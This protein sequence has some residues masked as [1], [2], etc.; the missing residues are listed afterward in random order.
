[1]HVTNCIFINNTGSS[2]EAPILTAHGATTYLKDNTFLNNRI[3]DGTRGSIGNRNGKATIISE[4]GNLYDGNGYWNYDD[5][6]YYSFNGFN[7]NGDTKQDGSVIGCSLSS[8]L[9]SMGFSQVPNHPYSGPAY[10]TNVTAGTAFTYAF[11]CATGKLTITGSGDMHMFDYS[12]ANGGYGDWQPW[13]LLNGQITSIVIGDNIT[14]TGEDMFYNCNAVT[15]ITLPA[16]FRYIGNY[17]F[18]RCAALTSIT[19]NGTG[20]V[21]EP[22]GTR[23]FEYINVEGITLNIPDA[24]VGTYATSTLNFG[25]SGVADNK[26]P[27]LW[28]DFNIPQLMITFDANGG[29]W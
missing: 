19:I 27:T 13:R 15:N 23:Q 4:G 3:N 24:M 12:N 29:E 9:S 21:V 2:L 6:R 16:G 14:S 8:R 20:P 25:V 1:M 18:G 10:P 22:Y 7:G 17:S 5:K 26:T 11:D 28:R